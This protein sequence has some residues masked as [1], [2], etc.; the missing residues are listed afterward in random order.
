MP[1]LRAAKHGNGSPDD[2][3]ATFFSLL[4]KILV[5]GD[6]GDIRDCARGSRNS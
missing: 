4:E 5:T 1:R 6:C 3:T 2:K